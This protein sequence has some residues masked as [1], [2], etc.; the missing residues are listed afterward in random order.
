LKTKCEVFKRFQEFRALVENQTGKKIKVLRSENGGEYTSTKFAEF[1]AE[2]GIWR[3]LAIP[4]NP[5]QNRVVERRNMAIVGATR[6]ML[7][8]E[9][10][11]LFL[12]V[13]ACGIAIYLQ[14]KNPH[15]VLETKTPEEA[16][17]RRRLDVEHLCIFGCFTYSH[18]L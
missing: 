8:D 7:H 9:A 16:F 10:F 4:N 6:L 13:E 5:Q 2:Q 12:W 15:R 3:Q 17:T 1:C 18:V 11:P 14:N